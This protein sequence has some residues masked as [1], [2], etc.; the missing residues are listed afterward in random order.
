[1]V[2]RSH[3]YDIAVSFAGAQ[4]D[5]VERV[6]RACEHLGLKV[7]Y[8]KN[9]TVDLWGRNFIYEMRAVYGGNQARYFI[10]FLSTDYFAGAYPRDEFNAAMVL[11]I[12]REPDDGY[13]LPIMVDRVDVPPELLSPAIGYLRAEQYTVEGLA[14]VIANRVRSAHEKHEEPRAI[15]DVVERALKVRLP[16]IAPVKFSAYDTLETA[17]MRVGE[18]FLQASNELEPFG[19]TCRVRTLNAVV[20]VRVEAHGQAVC[21]LRL[22][23]DDS[24][25]GGD[26][27]LAMSFAWPRVMGDSMN[28][29]VTATWD[30]E[31]REAKL[32]LNDL[33][34]NGSEDALL[35]ADELFDALWQKIVVFIER[36]SR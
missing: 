19:Y 1:M 11:A 16:R 2:E 6:V 26:D 14:Q 28:G 7:F 32:K 29:W 21:E 13:I 3:T 5:Y 27:R 10:P 9:K 20:S 22:R 36:R 8:D 18:L 12:E 24:G 31:S 23:F 30:S 15:S 17:L 33:S 4:R 25:F 35:T 34:V